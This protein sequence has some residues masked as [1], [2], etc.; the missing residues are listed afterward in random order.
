M[1]RRKRKPTEHEGEIFQTKK[2]PTDTEKKRKQP[3]DKAEESKNT[4]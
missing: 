4:Y 1:E 3:T 2:K